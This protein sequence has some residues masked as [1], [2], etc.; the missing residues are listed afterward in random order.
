MSETSKPCCG[1]C[2]HF[3]DTS[4]SYVR[5]DDWERFG[6]CR[7][8]LPPWVPETEGQDRFVNRNYACDLHKPQ[9]VKP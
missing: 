6:L 4:M 9:E 1:N 3:F 8:V 2:K 5:R 7:I